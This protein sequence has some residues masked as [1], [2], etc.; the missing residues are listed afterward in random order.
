MELELVTL[1]F[2]FL[3]KKYFQVHFQ[4][5]PIGLVKSTMSYVIIQML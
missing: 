5:F 4:I 3:W 2:T 1:G